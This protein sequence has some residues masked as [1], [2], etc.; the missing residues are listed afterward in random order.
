V[1]ERI[2]VN[3][4]VTPHGLAA[5]TCSP[6]ARAEGSPSASPKHP[7]RPDRLAG[8]DVEHEPVTQHNVT[9]W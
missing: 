1:G 9:S 7:P 4:R 5:L 3:R 2:G 8:G 6:L